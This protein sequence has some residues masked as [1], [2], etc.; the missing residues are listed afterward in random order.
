[1]THARYLHTA[2]LLDPKYVKGRLRGDIL[3]T[4]GEDPN[5]M[6][7]GSAEL[8]DPVA[9]TFTAIG[10]MTT[11]RA[12]H[13]ATLI[14]SG[15]YQGWVLIGG[16]IDDSGNSLSSAELFNP[17]KVRF[18]KAGALNVARSSSG[19]ASFAP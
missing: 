6:V 4:G 18:L 7:L 8:Y 1:M 10:S 2:T 15:K 13:S 12:F 9:Q 11:A 19:I 5:G 16:G 3:I 17:K 14:T